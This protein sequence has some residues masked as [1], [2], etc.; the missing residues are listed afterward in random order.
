MKK[1]LFL[2]MVMYLT[3]FGLQAQGTSTTVSRFAGEYIS[4]IDASGVWEI[5]LTQ[6]SA[7]KVELT[8]PERLKDQ[9]ILTLREGE[10]KI[11]FQGNVQVKEGEK[12]RAVIVCSAL[13]EIDL[14]GACK[15][16]GNG[17]F[18]GKDIKFDL[19][20]AARVNMVSPVTASGELKVEL[21]GASRLTM[22]NISAQRFDMDLSGASALELAGTAING[23]IEAS[24][25][26][27]FNL[28]AFKVSNVEVDLSG[29]TN[30]KLNVSERITG[31][32]SGASKLYYMGGATTHVDMSGA[33][34]LKQQ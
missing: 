9:L 15:L 3:V 20:G 12:F 6:G 28:N 2:M 26:S 22:R 17:N 1:G 4:E 29:S 24:G 11:K 10:L 27:K 7:T 30:G 18:S 21:S 8:F 31:E 32:M 19:S 34:S 25:A 23:K 14:S 33:S 13:K 16:D 5:L